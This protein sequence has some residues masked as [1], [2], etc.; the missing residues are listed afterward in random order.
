MG[1]SRPPPRSA[2]DSALY[3]QS[4][5]AGKRPAPRSLSRAAGAAGRARTPER[6]PIYP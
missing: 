4:R 3:P 6:R 5:A 1:T 2:A